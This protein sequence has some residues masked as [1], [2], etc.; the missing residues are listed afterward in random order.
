MSNAHH[1]TAFHLR[2]LPL[3]ARL[4]LTLFMIALGFGY[5]AGLVQMHFS[6]AKSGTLLPTEQ[7]VIDIFHGSTGPAVS[8]LERLLEAPEDAPF[9][10]NGS[11]RAA[12]T[13][14]A[15][16]WKKD[17]KER[18][19]AEVRKEREGE[20]LALLEY[21][22]A[23]APEADW[24]NDARAIP[25]SLKDQPLTPDFVGEEEGKKFIRIKSLFE[26]RCTRCH[27]PSGGFDKKAA[28]YP[29]ETHEQIAR[30]STTTASVGMSLEK[31]AMFTHAHF[32][33]FAMIYGVAGLVFS[34]TSYPGLLRLFL[35]PLPLLA[36]LV[37]MAA[38]WLV[39]LDPLWGQVIMVAGAV[40]G[41]GLALQILLTVFNLFGW[42]GRAVLLLLLLV[43][44]GG[45]WQVKVKWIDPYLATKQ[46]AARGA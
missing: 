17:I 27:E 28:A 33:S 39:I 44:L 6:H 19:E 3:P 13:T 21:I 43:T 1:T 15:S 14:K 10:G 34:L 38:W 24:T 23:G 36:Q 22:R 42:K 41:V 4:T 26:A 12:F 30:Y 40:V 9:N 20:R 7:D 31:R 37:E 46:P 2:Q 18:P 16:G 5:L 29:L 11:M 25:D 45:S 32:L 8:K 35:A